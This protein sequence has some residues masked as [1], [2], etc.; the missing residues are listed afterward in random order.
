VV[1][2]S[3]DAAAV[4]AAGGTYA[5]DLEHALAVARARSGKAELDVAVMPD[6]SDLVPRAV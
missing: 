3:L 5:P 6:A 2:S 4:T 1:V